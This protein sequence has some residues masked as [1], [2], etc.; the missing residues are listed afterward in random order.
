[1]SPAIINKGTLA[2][3]RRDIGQIPPGQ[4]RTLSV[5]SMYEIE[6]GFRIDEL[7]LDQFVMVEGDWTTRTLLQCGALVTAKL[8]TKYYKKVDS[9]YV[10]LS[11]L[12]THKT[13]PGRI[14]IRIVN[15][16]AAFSD[17]LMDAHP[18]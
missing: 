8:T 12:F 5:E 14:D 15:W 6:K 13:K 11:R 18:E 16:A 1:M 2:T 10:D 17:T 3:L 7:R 9:M 4:W